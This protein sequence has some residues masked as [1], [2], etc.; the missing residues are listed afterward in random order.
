MKRPIWLILIGLLVAV[1][2]VGLA[3]WLDPSRDY[4]GLLH[5]KD[6]S[7]PSITTAS[8][9]EPATTPS[10]PAASTTAPSFDVV[11]VSEDG[12]A[13]LAGRAQPRDE[14]IIFDN[15]REIGRTIAD[16]R[17]E[18]VF[19]PD[20]PLTPGARSLRLQA[21]N[22]DG[23]QRHSESPVVLVVPEQGDDPVLALKP[24]P[25]GGS[26]LLQGPNSGAITLSID[27]SERDAK[28]RLF[29]AGRAGR[30]GT[31][32]L[33]LDN[34]ALG[35]SPATPEKGWRVTVS[36]PGKG[37]TLRADLLDNQGKVVARIEVPFADHFTTLPDGT[38]VTVEKGNSLWLIAR[39]IYG[40]GEAYTVIYAANKGQIRD[41]DLIYPGQVFNLPARIGPQTTH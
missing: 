26:T 28:G 34:K 23:S 25:D 27:L 35:Q 14:V 1:A 3:L 10:S 9:G 38:T 7:P 12:H 20:H 15:D 2:A 8:D 31:V 4:F 36:D 22:P 6:A 40:E 17:G 37:K 24:L 33:Y 19:V 39:R 30:A 5:P 32:Q 41:P 13:V 18:W 29:F 16:N 21:A 11:R